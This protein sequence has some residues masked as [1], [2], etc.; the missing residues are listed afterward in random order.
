MTG[1]ISTIAL[2]GRSVALW[3]VAAVL[4]ENLPPHWK[5]ML[6]EDISD[7]ASAAL[8]LPCASRF[9]TQLGIDA[10]ALRAG[11]KARFGLGTELQGWQGDG[12]SFFA[13][14][15]GTL[16]A[17]NGVALH[18]IMLRA[19][20]MYEEPGRLPHLFQPVRFTARAAMAGK[21]AFPSDDPE[22]PLGLLGPTVQIAADDYAGLLQ[23]HCG[24]KG[25]E[26]IEGRPAGVTLKAAGG[27]LETVILEDGNIV[28][29]DLF[30]DV[31]G[32]I[33]D[34]AA[35]AFDAG[36]SPLPILSG[37][38][39]V[40]SAQGERSP[41]E[42]LH[43]VA[44]AQASGFH[45]DTPLS[46]GKAT[47]LVYAV[48][49]INDDAA[50]TAIGADQQPEA[51]A[52]AIADTPWTCNLARLGPASAQ[53]G[54]LFSADMVLL[55][56]QAV[57]LAASLPVSLRMEVE[58]ARFNARHRTITRQARD[59]TL[60]PFALSRHE[61]PFWTATRDARLPETLH[62]RINQFE[63]RGRLITFDNE[64]FDAQSWID[65]LIGFGVVPRRFDQATAAL[66]M[67]RI[68]Q[69][70]KRMVDGFNAAIDAMPEIAG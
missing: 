32:V 4:L 69:V 43:T 54:P 22:S 48:A 16:P 25:C 29:A 66:D 50:R 40:V 1:D 7:A 44:R 11:G 12:S 55:Q 39:R 47:T 51:F 2:F 5:L 21:F 52:P 67:P 63:S 70:L 58:A 9:H 53:L 19:A 35:D 31:S 24:P 38:D 37:L 49:D 3:P 60:L 45:I 13:A 57:E 27:A 17:V 64:L 62:L 42:P 61:D 15:S 30:I 41:E 56:E 34:L 46:S 18:H 65:M 8:T 28:S 6:V 59:F 23:T 10:D 36:A 14:P 26:L 33:S 68:A 20:Q